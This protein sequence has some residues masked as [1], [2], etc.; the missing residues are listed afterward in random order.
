MVSVLCLLEHLRVA[1]DVPW[2][3]RARSS[4]SLCLQINGV[5]IP[6]DIC[7]TKCLVALLRLLPRRQIAELTFDVGLM[8]VDAVL[9]RNARIQSR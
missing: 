4:H 5:E 8:L 6:S 1:V 3:P 7:R 9:L 2:R